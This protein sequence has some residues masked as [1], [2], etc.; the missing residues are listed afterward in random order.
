MYT[1]YIHLEGGAKIKITWV[2]SQQLP[3]THLI[4]SVH[5]LCFLDGQVA[6]VDLKARGMDIPG[7]HMEHGETPE[8]CFRR[9]VLEE[10]YLRGGACTLL[11]YT[12]VDNRENTTWAPESP[13]PQVGYMVFYRME[14]DEVLPF[15][16]R[17][18]S[19]RRLFVAPEDV[20]N[21]H[22]G[23]SEMSAMILA[24]ALACQPR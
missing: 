13:Y 24:A 21:V 3:P 14:V 15:E 2:P 8:D 6:L 12:E 18:E 19:S 10:A 23:W 20:P 11:G 5:G 4:T 16:G 17:F 7:G 9:E 1:E 22:R